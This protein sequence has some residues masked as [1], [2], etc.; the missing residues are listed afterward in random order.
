MEE[1]EM[2][3]RSGHVVEDYSQV[4]FNLSRW[5]EHDGNGFTVEI[6]RAWAGDVAVYITE[7]ENKIKTLVRLLGL[8]RESVVEDLN[9]CLHV[10]VFLRQRAENIDFLTKLLS[11]ID[12]VLKVYE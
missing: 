4:L 10:R 3:I 9:A 5:K 2:I 12:E 11:E 7:I 6:E 1:N 8:A